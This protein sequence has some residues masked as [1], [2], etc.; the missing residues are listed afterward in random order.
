MPPT[1]TD[2][3]RLDFIIDNRLLVLNHGT[4]ATVRD[5]SALIIGEGVDPRAAI[6][7]A[8][9]NRPGWV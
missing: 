6:D 3:Q 5:D 4:L 9:A 8:R 2:S 1:I 7:D